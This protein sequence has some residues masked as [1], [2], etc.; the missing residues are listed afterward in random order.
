MRQWSWLLPCHYL[1]GRLLLPLYFCSA[2]E[3]LC[4]SDFRL[5]GT[6]LAR[7]ESPLVTCCC[8]SLFLLIKLPLKKLKTPKVHIARWCKAAC[9]PNIRQGSGLIN[10][11]PG[12]IC[13][14]NPA[15]YTKIHKERSR[16]TVQARGRAYE[17]GLSFNSL[18]LTM[19]LKPE[20]QGVRA[21][22]DAHLGLMQGTQ[23]AF[24]K[25][26]DT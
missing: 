12:I 24:Q 9:L 20:L 5:C 3:C 11:F 17:E 25:E 26:A 2:N 16:N 6:V 18:L 7:A 22:E 19:N 8:L 23:T 21:K 15:S 4:D 13:L 14:Q 10:T 1:S